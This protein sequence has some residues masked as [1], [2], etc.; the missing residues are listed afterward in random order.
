MATIPPLQ[1]SKDSF[2]FTSFPL[3]SFEFEKYLTKQLFPP[4][5]SHK[6]NSIFC[7]T[8]QSRRES[9]MSISIAIVGTDGIV[10]ATDSRVKVTN[11]NIG[12]LIYRDV[13]KKLWILK[14]GEIVAGLTTVSTNRGLQ[15]WLV[16]HYINEE[17]PLVPTK[18]Q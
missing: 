15:E 17:L 5:D 14:K 8:I 6:D 1:V 13:G 11:E 9:S 3:P 10:L 12:M 2:S 16:S 4:D 18:N 7:D